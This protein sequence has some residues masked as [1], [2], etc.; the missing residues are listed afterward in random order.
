MHGEA[1]VLPLPPCP[2]PQQP[3]NHLQ[4]AG[5]YPF[6]T[7]PNTPS[8]APPPQAHSSLKTIRKK[9]VRKVLDYIKKLADDEAKCGKNEEGDAEGGWAQPLHMAIV[10]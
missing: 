8:L 9:L 6:L 10:R 4:E 5:V 1:A 2:G 3:R 7:P